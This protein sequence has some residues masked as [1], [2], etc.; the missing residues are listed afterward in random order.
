RA[1][2]RAG[3]LARFALPRFLSRYPMVVE[4]LSGTVKFL[5]G[6]LP[7]SR[8]IV[9]ELKETRPNALILSPMVDLE[10]EQFEWVRAA[11]S[12]GVPTCLLV[13][14]WDNLTNKGCVQLV[15]DRVMLWNDF[16][17]C[18]AVEMHDIPAARI[19]ITGAQL[20]DEWFARKPTRDYKEFCRMFG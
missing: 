11:R 18:E 8:E 20:N 16:Q 13:A 9:E 2:R 19:V 4:G 7:P 10:T 6:G 5:D 17:K 3:H 14:S 12:V 1:E 15:P